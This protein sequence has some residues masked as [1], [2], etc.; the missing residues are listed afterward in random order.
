VAK[1]PNGEFYN[2]VVKAV[3]NV[4]ETLGLSKAE[5]DKMGLGSRDVPNC[6]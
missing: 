4:T 2:K 6:P 5:F 3:P 1:A